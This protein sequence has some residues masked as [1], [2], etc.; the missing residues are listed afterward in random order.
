[1]IKKCCVSDRDDG[2]VWQMHHPTHGH[3]CRSAPSGRNHGVSFRSQVIT[4]T[5]IQLV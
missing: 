1:M 4:A 3:V 5:Y 2:P